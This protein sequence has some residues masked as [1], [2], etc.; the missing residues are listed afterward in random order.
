[1]LQRLKATQF[2][3]LIPGH[4]PLQSDAKYIDLLIK[5][6]TLLNSQVEAAVVQGKSLADVARSVDLTKVEARF[7][8][9]EPILK[10]FFGFYFKDPGTQSAYNVAKGIENEKLTED[11]PKASN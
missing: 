4:G 1:V 2:E 11:P 7:T 5:A 6:L 9:S 8:N 3:T 10:R